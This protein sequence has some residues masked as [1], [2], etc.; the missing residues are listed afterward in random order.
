MMRPEATIQFPCGCSADMELSI[1]FHIYTKNWKLCW[2]HKE[3]LLKARTDFEEYR[4]KTWE[5]TVEK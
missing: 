1:N 4:A 3:L 2:K 5:K